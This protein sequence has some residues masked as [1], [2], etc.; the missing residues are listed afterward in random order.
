MNKPAQHGAALLAAML[1]VT[2]VATLAAAALWQQW[3]NV[4]VE[5]AERSRVQSAW[6]LNGALDW[7]RLILR[8]D[9][10]NVDHLGEPWAVPLQE[11]RLSTFLA[12]DQSNNSDSGDAGNV[13]L[14]GDITDLQSRLD[15][16]VL[17]R[18]GSRNDKGVEAF[19]R[20]FEALGLP[21]SQ[22]ALLAENIRFAG[23]ISVDNRSSSRAPLMPQRVDQLV[24]LGLSADT[25]AALEP[26]V[27]VLPVPEG[28]QASSP[29]VNLNTAPAEVIYA[30]GSN[31]SLADAR[32]LV[33]QRERQP[34][35][36]ITDVKPLLPAEGGFV[37]GMAGYG[38]TYFEIRGRLRIDD[39]VIE[40]RSIVQRS[41]SSVRILRR[42]RGASESLSQAA[43]RR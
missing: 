38:S 10:G 21:Q 17:H 32:K 15:I 27:T 25:V 13:F 16:H 41:G 7:A 14:S 3:R 4:E 2:M 28:G 42:E 35:R 6:I 5:A 37:D 39:V 1:T 11:A 20:L 24:W 34:F 43:V 36:S 18:A 30:V 29:A 31:I 22:L 33:A 40:E 9:R 26:Y 19:A 12:A 23:D 8:E